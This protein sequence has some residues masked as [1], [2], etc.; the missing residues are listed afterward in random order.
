MRFDYTLDSQRGGIATAMTLEASLTEP[1]APYELVYTDG[2]HGRVRVFR[3]APATLPEFLRTLAA[4]ADRPLLVHE[5]RR[6]SYR[7]IFDRTA[8]IAYELG[9]RGVTRGSRVVIAMRNSC[10]CVAAILAVLAI[11]AVPVFINSRGTRDEITDGV[12]MARCSI[13]LVDQRC[14][15]ALSEAPPAGVA[16]LDESML[17]GMPPRDDFFSRLATGVAPDDPAA[18][19]FTSGTAG[20]PKAAVLTH[21][22]VMTSLW[23]NL[24]AGALIGLRTAE[25]LGI[26]M[27]TLAAQMQSPCLLLVYPLFHTSG[28]HSGLLPT[29]A[30]GARCVMMKRWSGV[31]ALRLIEAERITQAPGVPTMF[32]DMLKVEERGQFDLSSLTSIATG[33]QAMP[34]NLLADMRAAFPR[35]VIGNGYGLTEANGAVSL[36]VGED[37]LAR[38]T[39]SG[40]VLPTLEVRFMRTAHTEAAPGEPGEVWVRG[41]SVMREYFDDPAATEEA[42]HEGWLR[43]GDVGYLDDEGFIYIVDRKRDMIISAGENIYCA[44]VERVLLEHPGVFEASTFGVVDDRLGEKLVAAVVPRGGCDVTEADLQA[45]IGGRLAAY[46]VPRRVWTSDTPLVRN[47]MGK[48]DK[49]AMRQRFAQFSRG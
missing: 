23:A 39:T 49:V 45:W 15:A 34:V 48:V 21:R 16:I 44:E 37:F 9:N 26:D 8:G 31:D 30:R 40:V 11:G 38:P 2:P 7:Q 22:G 6:L 1:G 35:A 32:W 33:G 28:L 14:A 25:K 17:V 3:H 24:Y 47:D 5:S 10:E 42:F 18:I 29:L 13:M 36:V 41:A 20:R 43:T 12:R 46:K 27:A 4:F 19:L